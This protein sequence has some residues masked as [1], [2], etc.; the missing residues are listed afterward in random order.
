M[1]LVLLSIL[2]LALRLVNINKLE[3]LWNDEYVSWFVAST[4]FNEGF[5][6]EIL[7]QCHMP[8]YYFYLKPF[9]HCSDLILR[10]TSVLQFL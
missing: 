1:Y 9:A 4:P 3:G 8:L 2:G 10:L 6:Q 5:F 7:N